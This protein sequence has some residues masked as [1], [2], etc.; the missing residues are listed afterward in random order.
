VDG[1]PQLV[2][3]IR[4]YN[5]KSFSCVILKLRRFLKLSFNQ[6]LVMSNHKP[7]SNFK[8]RMLGSSPIKI[9]N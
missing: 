1:Y 3:E 9:N 6:N 4:V 7:N 8:N 5:S 2:L